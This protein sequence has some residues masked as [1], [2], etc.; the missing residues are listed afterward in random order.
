MRSVASVD[1]EAERIS[2]DGRENRRF[3]ELRVLCVEERELQLRLNSSS[4]GECCIA[5]CQPGLA[6][7]PKYFERK[8]LIERQQSKRGRTKASIEHVGGVEIT[9]NARE[10]R[11]GIALN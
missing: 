7:G 4:A 3:A 10:S 2:L 8:K 6:V 9:G 1:Q 11:T 5:G